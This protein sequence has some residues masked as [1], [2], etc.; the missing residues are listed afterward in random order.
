MIS[1][2]ATCMGCRICH[3]S[4]RPRSLPQLW[5]CNR[6]GDRIVVRRES[7]EAKTAGGIILPD[8]GQ[9]QAAARYRAR[10]RPRQ[11][12]VP[13]APSAEM[14]LKVGDKVLFTSWA[15]DEFQR[16]RRQKAKSSSCTK[17]T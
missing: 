8:T 16:P 2:H 17:A 6:I 14:Q 1:G 4:F 9:E 15:G 7:A 13:T 10:R 5:V 12:E 11:D 3:A